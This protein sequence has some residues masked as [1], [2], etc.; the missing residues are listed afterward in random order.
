MRRSLLLVAASLSSSSRLR[1]L[2]L[3]LVERRPGQHRALARVRRRRGRAL[4]DAA[5]QFNATHPKIHVT[6]QNYGN[7]DY[8][9]R[10]C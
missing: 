9:S 6:T 8:A 4:A 2:G 10:R 3:R 1:R 7:A 5:K